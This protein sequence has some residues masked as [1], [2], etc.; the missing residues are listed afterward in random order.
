M[1]N[2]KIISPDYYRI[3]PDGKYL[4][5]AKQT[6]AIW[7]SVYAE[8]GAQ[9][10][11]VSFQK[12]YLITGPPGAG[13]TYFAE[14]SMPGSGFVIIDSC[15]CTK[16]NR[17]PIVAICK[18]HGVKIACISVVAPMD[19]ALN[20]NASRTAN[21]RVPESYIRGCYDKFEIPTTDEGFCF[22]RVWESTDANANKKLWET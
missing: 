9:L 1:N 22:V 14:H 2:L 18:S 10:P 13:K 21:R 7:E 19:C 4:F 20:R 11:L 8:M 17:R 16:E 12:A 6:Q 3:Q 15:L 5:D